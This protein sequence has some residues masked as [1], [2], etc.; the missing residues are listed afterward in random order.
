[1]PSTLPGWANSLTPM[2]LSKPLGLAAP[3]VQARYDHYNSI[4]FINAYE[5]ASMG[6]ESAI[7]LGFVDRGLSPDT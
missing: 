4:E 1:M 2:P 6:I 3:P 5:I 7:G